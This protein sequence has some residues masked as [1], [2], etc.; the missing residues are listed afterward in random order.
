MS[1]ADGDIRTG[2]VEYSG[3]GLTVAAYEAAPRGDGPWP[4]LILIHEWWGVT[5]H[6]KDVAGRYAREGFRVTAPDLYDG[7]TTSD[8]R[9][10]SELMAGLSSEQGLARL[11]VVLKGLRA[12]PEVSAVG[13]TGFCMGGTFALRLACE[14]KLEA[15]APFYGDIPEDTGF[16]AGLTCPLLF[17]GGEKDAWITTAK[18]KRLETALRHYHRE[19][20]VRVYAGAEHAFFNDTRPEVYRASDAADAWEKVVAFMGKHLV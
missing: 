5:S 8:A 14:Q 19:G 6:I 20:E 17:I 15:A 11:T 10:A 1:A 3:D 4:A 7:V 12:R 18:M 13:V 16:I 9:E 2:W